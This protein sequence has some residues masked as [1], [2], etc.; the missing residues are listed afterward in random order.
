MLQNPQIAFRDPELRQCAV[1]LDALGQ[2]KARSGNF[3]TVYRGYRGDGREFAIRVFNRRVDER[4]ERY[5]E[6]SK[7]IEGRNVA[8]LVGFQYDERGIRAADGKF[9]P[10]LTMDWVPGVTLFE[11]TRDRCREG[12]REALQIGA[13]AWRVLVNELAE[14]QIAHGDLQHGNL[15]VSSEGQFKLVDYDCMSVPALF[16]RRNLE[17]GLPPYQHPGRTGETNLFLGVDNFSALVIYVALR[18]LAAAPYLW[19]TYVEA[20]GYDKLLFRTE[21]FQNPAGSAL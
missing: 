8:S 7:Y 10:L 19:F 6:V 18:G 20:Q 14:N 2:P 12:Y 17:V 13:E 3:A 5:E 16:G 11:W 9:Y 4:L 1:E 15:L 21:D